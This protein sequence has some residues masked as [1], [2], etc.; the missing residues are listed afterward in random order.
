MKIFS[1]WQRFVFGLPL[2]FL[3]AHL[4]FVMEL[5]KNSKMEERHKQLNKKFDHLVL[6][7]MAGQGLSN[8]LQCQGTK[9]LNRT[10][11]S[12]SRSGVDGSITF[13]T[14]FTIYNTSLND[15]DDRSNTVVGN[16]S[17]NNV[18]RSMALLNVFINFIQVAMPQSKVI[19][20][21]DPMSDLSVQ[22]NRVSLYPIQGEYS[23]DKLMLQRIRSYITFLETRLQQLSQKPR[24]VIHYIFTDSDIA[25]VDDLGQVFRDHPNFHLALT[26]RN[27]KAQP[28]NSGFIAVKGTQEAMLRAKLF[29]QEVLKVYSTKYRNASRMLG[30]QLAL[31]LVVMSKPHFDARRFS[32]GLAFSED[33]GA[34]SVLFLP[35]SLYNWTPPE[36][37]G[38]FHGMPLDVKVV[39]FKGSRKR[40]MLESWNFY[41]SS[42]DIS[43]MLCLILGSGRTKYDF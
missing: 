29:L 25:V 20:L 26:F 35:C 22:R 7:H 24:D 17:Y 11:S 18:D 15:V 30:D 12:E 6:G 38:Q 8:R 36:G 23:R 19:I 34:T 27:N 1:G 10:H 42:Q 14:V 9:A 13:V 3:F 43:D 4:V 2:F 33:I 40:L 21:T 31:A 39:H 16:A 5:H 32:K 28:L 37:A 41:S